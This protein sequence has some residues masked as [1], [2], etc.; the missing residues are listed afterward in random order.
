VDVR[1]GRG[2]RGGWRGRRR[3][4][5]L[6]LKKNV[7]TTTYKCVQYNYNSTTVTEKN[8]KWKT[9][10]KAVRCRRRR[11]KKVV[12]KKN[13]GKNNDRV[14]PSCPN[15]REIWLKIC[16]YVYLWKIRD[17]VTI[18][19]LKLVFIT[20]SL[21]DWLMHITLIIWTLLIRSNTR[22]LHWFFSYNSFFKKKNS[23][24]DFFALMRLLLDLN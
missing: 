8:Q 10:E 13:C 23:I 4:L 3:K 1:C 12:L 14:E 20:T 7:A 24:I 16:V 19:T 18:L 21:F 22:Y 2:Q 11:K 5:E 17:L 15:E 9:K 6:W